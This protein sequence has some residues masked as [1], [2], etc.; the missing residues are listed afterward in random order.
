MKKIRC[1]QP[2]NFTAVE[3]KKAY[4]K[5]FF[6]ILLTIGF[7]YMKNYFEE[8]KE[9]LLASNT[10]ITVCTVKGAAFGKM[11]GN[12]FEYFVEDKKYKYSD[13]NN[14]MFYTGEHFQV[15]YSKVKPEVCEILYTMPVIKNLKSYI[16][17]LGKVI[18]TEFNNP[19][20]LE[21]TYYYSGKKYH[22][23]VYI[24]DASK[25]KIGNEYEVLIKKDKPRI[26]YLSDMF[27]E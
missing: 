3:K 27:D 13:T 7:F 8:E 23:S 26:A 10:G 14:V 15:K 17:D 24:K 21:F 11:N 4:I 20:Y 6:L 5:L 16:K 22:R 2:D 1:I 12:E 25:Y 18:R 9:T 19:N